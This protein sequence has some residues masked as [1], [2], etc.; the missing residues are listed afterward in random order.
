[1]ASAAARKHGAVAPEEIFRRANRAVGTQIWKRAARMVLACLPPMAADDL[2]KRL[3]TAIAAAIRDR[4][5][6]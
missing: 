5:R 1:M 6:G 3:P 4:V 2:D